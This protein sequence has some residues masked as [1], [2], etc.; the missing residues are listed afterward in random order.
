MSCIFW[1]LYRECWVILDGREWDF[2]NVV[3]DSEKGWKVKTEDEQQSGRSKL[4]LAKAQALAPRI[5]SWPELAQSQCH[6]QTQGQA[7]IHV[8]E[9]GRYA[10]LRPRQQTPTSTEV[11]DETT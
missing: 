3:R 1:D 5:R 4:K 9:N 6:C 2:K 10:M 8:T 7:L 11:S